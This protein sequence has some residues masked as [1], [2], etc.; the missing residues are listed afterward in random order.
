MCPG[1]YLRTIF[2]EIEQDRDEVGLGR[3]LAGMGDL[4]SLCLSFPIHKIETKMLDQHH[5][6][7]RIQERVP[8]VF[9]TAPGA[10]LAGQCLRFWA[11]TA[12]GTF[13][14]P[15]LKK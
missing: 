12:G 15:W 8:K 2:K 14:S 7:V 10:S 13:F 1:H 5:R 6:L 9:E 11:C 3:G 4:A